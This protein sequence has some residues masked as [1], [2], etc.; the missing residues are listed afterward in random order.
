Q[1][2]REHLLRSSLASLSDSVAAPAGSV[3]VFNSLNWERDGIV[4]IDLEKGMQLF[5]RA[6][7]DLVPITPL[8]F[9]NDFVRVEFLAKNIPA[10]GYKTYSIKA[11]KSDFGVAEQ[12]KSTTL[13]SPF[14]RVELDPATG[15][16]Q[17]IFD[18]ELKKELVDAKSPYKFGQYL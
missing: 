10:V 8:H 17:G 4:S 18:R 2:Q 12:T 13:E 6:T 11:G 3:L 14:Y 15:A 5:D 1:D 16:V 7:G 9:G